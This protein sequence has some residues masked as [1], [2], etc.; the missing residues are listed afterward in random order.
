ML[1]YFEA[2]LFRTLRS[3]FYQIRPSLIEDMT[4]TFSLTFFLD[5][6]RKYKTRSFIEPVKY[7]FSDM[8]CKSM[9]WWLVWRQP[10]AASESSGTSQRWLAVSRP[11][12]RPPTCPENRTMSRSRPKPE[13]ETPR[14]FC[15]IFE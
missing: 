8:T 2:N 13:I 7:A 11:W 3:N 10:L 9:S 14:Y 1:Q 12:C 4:K 15:P 5:T 6:C